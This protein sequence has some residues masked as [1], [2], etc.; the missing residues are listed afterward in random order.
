V[1]SLRI[2]WVV[3]CAFA[4]IAFILAL[5]FTK[6]FTLDRQLV[7]EQ[8]LRHGARDRR[9]EVEEM[10]MPRNRTILGIDN[11]GNNITLDSDLF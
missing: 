3:M 5:T 8:G 6:E 10:A 4:C 1:D 7:T 2:V 11:E 9:T